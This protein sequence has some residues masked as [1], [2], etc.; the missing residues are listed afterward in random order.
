MCCILNFY[1]SSMLRDLFSNL[2]Y[3][4]DSRISKTPKNH[5]VW[6]R[7]RIHMKQHSQVATLQGEIKRDP[8]TLEGIFQLEGLRG[9]K[10]ANFTNCNNPLP[11]DMSLVLTLKSTDIIVQLCHFKRSQS[12]GLDFQ[13]VSSWKNHEIAK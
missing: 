5:C 13:T 2:S 3:N 6:N 7:Q 10:L 9:T 8:K 1:T 11:L 4:T 12:L